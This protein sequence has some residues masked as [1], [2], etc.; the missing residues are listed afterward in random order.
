MHRVM[1]GLPVQQAIQSKIKLGSSTALTLVHCNCLFIFD[2]AAI[3]A[4]LL[5]KQLNSQA[6]FIFMNC[7]RNVNI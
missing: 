1:S 7:S 6:G 2:K 5:R 4:N 3:A